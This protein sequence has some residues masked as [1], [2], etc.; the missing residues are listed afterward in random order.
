MGQCR[1]HALRD[2]LVRYRDPH[3][4]RPTLYTQQTVCPNSIM[5]RSYGPHRIF[6]PAGSL[7]IFIQIWPYPRQNP[8]VAAPGVGLAG[9]PMGAQA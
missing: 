4:R 5:G 3:L 1:A 6:L 2:S 9:K 7:L 8:M